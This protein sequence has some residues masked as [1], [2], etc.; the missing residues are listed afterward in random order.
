MSTSVMAQEEN[1]NPAEGLWMPAAQENSEQRNSFTEP[2]QGTAPTWEDG[3][4]SHVW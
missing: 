1:S 4:L 2:K 3:M